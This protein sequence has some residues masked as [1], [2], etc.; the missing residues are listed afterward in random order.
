MT[1]GPGST[2]KVEDATDTGDQGLVGGVLIIDSATSVSVPALGGIGGNMIDPA[3]P[4]T[5]WTRFDGVGN[6][7]ELHRTRSLSARGSTPPGES[8]SLAAAASPGTSAH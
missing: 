1:W 6:I 3:M 2:L 5:R 8:S 7:G 4:T